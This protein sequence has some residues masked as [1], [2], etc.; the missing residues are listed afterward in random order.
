MVSLQEN[1]MKARDHLGS[2]ASSGLTGVLSHL[3]SIRSRNPWLNCGYAANEAA[4]ARL[5]GSTLHQDAS[6]PGTG[7]AH[8]LPADA[9]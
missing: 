5:T 6:V 2:P 1:T 7:R 9:V 3:T 8:A 4:S